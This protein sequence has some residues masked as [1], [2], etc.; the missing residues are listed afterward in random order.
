MVMQAQYNCGMTEHQQPHVIKTFW[1]FLLGILFDNNLE[2]KPSRQKRAGIVF[3]TSE[4]PVLEE[5]K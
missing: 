2:K 5:L 1:S 4:E 3:W